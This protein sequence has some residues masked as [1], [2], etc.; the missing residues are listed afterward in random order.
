MTPWGD[1]TRISQKGAAM[2][3]NLVTSL[4]YFGRRACAFV[5]FGM[6]PL[7]AQPGERPEGDS[8]SL[9]SL[10][11]TSVPMPP[12]GSTDQRSS[13]Q[14]GL[15]P[16]VLHS[17]TK[18]S[19]GST[20]GYRVWFRYWRREQEALGSWFLRLPADGAQTLM[21]PPSNR[22]WNGGMC[23]EVVPSHEARQHEITFTCTSE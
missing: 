18:I 19:V 2:P 10:H 22:A 15:A 17:A 11:V 7:L 23:F 12:S 4:W 13:A 6:M 20:S 3:A 5:V 14:P 21:L 9:G 1:I 16:L 8:R